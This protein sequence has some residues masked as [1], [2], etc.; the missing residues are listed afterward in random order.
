MKRGPSGDLVLL[1]AGDILKRPKMAV[2]LEAIAADPETFY[3]GQLAQDI[4]DDIKEY[5]R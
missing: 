2:T 4:V 3:K 5:G 1:E